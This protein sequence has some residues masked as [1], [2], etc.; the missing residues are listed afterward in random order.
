MHLIIRI[1]DKAGTLFVEKLLYLL[2]QCPP[3]HIIY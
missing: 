3:L 2:Y 1:K